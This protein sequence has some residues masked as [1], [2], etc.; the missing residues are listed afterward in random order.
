MS[1]TG[2]LN[3]ALSGLTTTSRMA[4]TVSSNLSNAVTDGY[5]RRSLELASLQ[6]GGVQVQ[7]V[8][9]LLTRVFWRIVV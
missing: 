8:N 1:I 9:R 6:L 4:E 7:A 2:A 5:G 3:N